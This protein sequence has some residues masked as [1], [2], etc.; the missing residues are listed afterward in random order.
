MALSETASCREHKKSD[1][2]AALEEAFVSLISR[3][4]RLR[5]QA[6][7]A[8]FARACIS[9]ED[10]LLASATRRAPLKRLVQ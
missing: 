8:W 4:L 1:P 7:L 2:Q 10:S 6:Y 5:L 9:A 3:Q